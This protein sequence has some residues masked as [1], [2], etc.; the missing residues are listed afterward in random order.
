MIQKNVLTLIPKPPYELAVP[1]RKVFYTKKEGIDFINIHN[2]HIRI[3]YSLYSISG[4]VLD[5]IWFDLDNGDGY[6]NI[7]K[8]HYWCAQKNIKHSAIFSG[9]GFHFYIYTKYSKPIA[10]IKAVL[11]FLQCKIA[12]ELNFS[13]DAIN[14]HSSDIDGH[15]V[16]DVRRVVTLPGTY[17]TKRRRWAISLTADEIENESLESIRDLAQKQRNALYI[18]N[19]NEYDITQYVD[20][21]SKL[22]FG[23]VEI[24]ELKQD[25]NCEQDK[26][27]ESFPPCIQECLLGTNNTDWR[28]RWFFTIWAKELGFTEDQTLKIAKKYFAPRLREDSLLNNYN[29]WRKVKALNYV[30]AKDCLLPS[31]EKMWVEGRCP[32]KCS[33]YIKE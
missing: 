7:Q 2:G 1:N 24:P 30:Y 13:I 10:D 19:D 32:G 3:F 31:C 9:G 26:I 11:S 6:N 12:T 14:C 16:G 22:H 18:I 21:K 20:I 33:Y 25:I 23:D 15:I 17:N 8:L 27:L 28:G 29:H 5:K 4:P